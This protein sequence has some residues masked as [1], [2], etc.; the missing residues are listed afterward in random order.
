MQNPFAKFLS[1][2]K[3]KELQAIR[4]ARRQ[5]IEDDRPKALRTRLNNPY[6][7]REE[8]PRIDKDFKKWFL[9]GEGWVYAGIII[10]IFG[11]LGYLAF[12]SGFLTVNN[13]QIQGTENLS[14]EEIQGLAQETLDSKFL[15]LIPLNNYLTFRPVKVEAA[16]YDNL[17]NQ[18]A[19]ESLEVAKKFPHTVE[20]SIKERV[21]GLTWVA[22]KNEFYYIDP[23]GVISQSIPA[24]EDLDENYPKIYD[25]NKVEVEL[26]QQVVSEELVNF[27][28]QVE[29]KLPQE[30]HLEIES[31]NIP[32]IQCQEKEYIMERVFAEEIAGEE[33]L[34]T[35]N[36]KKD[37]QEKF[38]SGEIDVDESLELLENINNQ[39]PESPDE[40]N[41]KEDKPEAVVWDVVYNP[42]DCDF[43]AINS[44]INITTTEGFEIYCDSKLDLDM[45]INNLNSV[46]NEK[47]D[48]SAQINYIDLRFPDRVYYK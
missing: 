29:N 40:G 19:L 24:E 41:K 2:D 3:E 45:Q 14:Q 22:D 7:Q 47:I 46:L 21:P 42:V 39:D 31:Y 17:E 16:I 28:L 43:V 35:K 26:D 48:D 33:N 23:E 20:I 1:S 9:N 12:G 27:V 25:P 36:K 8:T 32:Q 15:K 38:K 11:A 13:I 10:I 37:I 18:F 6:F 30:T 34:E 5:R 44:E 4:Q